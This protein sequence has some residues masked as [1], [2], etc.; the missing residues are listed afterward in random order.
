MYVY[1]YV[2][3]YKTRFPRVYITDSCLRYG[4]RVYM[5][6][7][8]YTNIYKYKHMYTY[9]HIYAQFI[10]V[11]CTNTHLCLRYGLRACVT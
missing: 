11:I 5:Y 6:V 8:V 3:V 10:Q 4:S 9:I 1:I 7:H 2:Y